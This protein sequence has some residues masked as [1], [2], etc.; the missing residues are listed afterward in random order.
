MTQI[1]IDKKKY[2]LLP[3][4]EYKALLIMAALKSKSIKKLALAQGRKYNKKLIRKWG[5]EK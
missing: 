5:A 4:K 3:E 2:V 1:I